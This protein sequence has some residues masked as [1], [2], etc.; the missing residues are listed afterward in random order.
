MK[1][2]IY[3]FSG[4]LMLSCSQEDFNIDNPN[5][6]NAAAVLSNAADFKNFNTTNHTTLFSNQIGFAGI[7]FRGLSDQFTTTNAFRSFW[8]YCDQP[9]RQINN[10]TSDDDL[11][12]S[13]ASPWGGY[14]GVIN[15]ANIIINNIENQSGSV[16]VSGNDLTQQELSAAYFDK[17]VAQGYLSMIYDKAYIVNP[18]TDVNALVF[19]S[20]T[21]M[22]AAA[23]ANIEKAVSIANAQSA[24]TYEI[25]PGGPAINKATFIQLAN[26]YMARFSIGVARTNA[27]ALTLDYDKIL[28]YANNAITSNFQPESKEDVLFN[29]LQDWSLFLLGSGAGYMPTDIKIAHLFQPSYPTDYPTDAT[30]L[31]AVTTSDPRINYYEYVGD[32]FG[33][34]RASRGRHLFSSYR[35]VRFFNGNNEN[36]TGLPCQ[37][38]PKA[39]IDYIKAEAY[40]RK[41]DIT[42]AVA[43]LDASPRKTVGNQSTTASAD[44]VRNS[45]IY[46]NSI[47]LDLASGMAVNW[48]F[49]RRHDL[50]QEGSPTMYPVPA[51]ELEIT[52]SPIYTFGSPANKGE[53]GTAS[54]SNDWRNIT[55]TY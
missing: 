3:L 9:R 47:E 38:F 17:G 50:L 23:I 30:I 26:A 52:Q 41:G 36:V 48:A 45:L 24:I 1:K 28:T 20:Y 6:P 31:P 46:E 53:V 19:S 5:Q 49:M 16:V 12:A 14:N 15:N 43:M 11:A 13:V 40:Y 27:E 55:L 32:K 51:S 37:I 42:N 7:Y 39:E 18:D 22:L 2:L 44:A 21:E 34:L 54:G 35:H 29:N 25:Y 33:F 8:N 4:L 10:S